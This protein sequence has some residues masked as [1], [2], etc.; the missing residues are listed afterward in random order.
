MSAVRKTLWRTHSL[1]CS[2]HPLPTLLTRLRVTYCSHNSLLL[3]QELAQLQ[4]DDSTLAGIVAQLE[5]GDMVD[6][7][8]LSKGILYC[9][10]KTRG[11]PKLVVPTAAIPMDFAYIHESQLDG[12]LGVFKTVSKIRSQIIWKGMDE[13]IRSRARACQACALSEPAHDSH[14]GLLASEVAQRP[15]QEIFIDHVGKLPRS[16]VGNTAILVC[17]DVFSKFV[18]FV[19]V[20]EATTSKPIKALNGSIFGSFTFPEVLVSDNAPCFTSKEFRQFCFGLGI[21]PLA[22]E[23][24]IYSLAHHFCKM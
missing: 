5:K 2:I 22:L 13:D 9:R 14:W 6:G 21:N 1:E 4:Q 18:W 16:K 17:V 10:S 23:L 15:M 19:P 12:H 20:K 3:F 8:I 24:D 11:Y 7:Y